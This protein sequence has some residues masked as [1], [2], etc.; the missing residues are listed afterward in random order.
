MKSFRVFLAIALLAGLSFSSGVY[1]VIDSNAPVVKLQTSCTEGG[2]ALNNCFETTDS[3]V[4]WMTTVRVPKPSAAA[5]LTVK[6]GPG[7]FG[8]LMLTCDATSGF[9]GNVSFAGSGRDQSRFQG[10]GFLVTHPAV[11]RNCTALDFADIKFVSPKYGYIDWGGGGTSVWENVDVAGGS[12]GWLETSC[13][14]S[15]GKH[16]WFSSRIFSSGFGANTPY[17]A[18]C[19]ESWFFGSEIVTNANGPAAWAYGNAQLHVYGSNLRVDDSVGGLTVPVVAF[20]AN[21]NGVVH[22]HG[23]GID[24]AGGTNSTVKAL[25]AAG[26]GMIH[27]NASSYFLSAGAGGT[28]MRADNNNGTGHIHAPY[29]WE[30]IPDPAVMPNFTSI[31]GAD[32][33]TVTT[34][35]SDGHPH[36]VVYSTNCPS[37]ARWYDQVDKVC[38]P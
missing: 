37:N 5:P 19:D 17:S 11:I 22:I 32:M 1:A 14:S 3:V 12:R 27:A 30:H 28:I 13:G 38:R 21:D 9:T 10:A 31:N 29:L 23:T 35:T 18:S 24:A 33:T 6:M 34:G 7:T 25:V 36:T 26:G 16:Y 20:Q 4:S 15:P 2:T 8:P